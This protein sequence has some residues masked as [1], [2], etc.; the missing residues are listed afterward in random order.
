M[1]EPIKTVE[2]FIA[3]T[4]QLDGR[5]L[6]YRGLADTDWRV[7][8]SALRRQRVSSE[9]PP[10]MAFQNYTKQ[11]L[12]NASLQG[13]RYQRDREMS[14]LELL[15]EL[16]HYGA[17]TCLIDFTE[18]SLIALWF[19]CRDELK[20]NGKVVAMATDDPNKFRNVT[21]EQSK[22]PILQFLNKG[23]LWQWTPSSLNNRIVAQLSVFVFGEG[24]IQ[25]N[26]YD[27]IGIEAEAK[28]SIIATL[29]GSFGLNDHRVFSD[30]S[31]YALNNAHDRPYNDY[32][33]E[34][35][36]YWGLSFHRQG[37]FENA[38]D[39]YGK[40]ISLDPRSVVS[41]DN[42]GSA[43]SA[44]GDHKAAISDYDKSIEIYPQSADAFYNRGNSKRALGQHK[45]AIAD[46]DRAIEINPQFADVYVN[47]GSVK[48]QMGDHYG[49]IADCDKALEIYPQLDVAFDN[50][51]SAKLELGNYQGSIADY[52]KS[53]EINPLSP[54][55]Y[56]NRG[57]VKRTMGDFQGAIQ[58]YDK[59]LEIEPRSVATYT[60]RAIAKK[61]I[62]DLAGAE[63]D[64]ERASEIQQ[65]RQPPKP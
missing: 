23:N 31:G 56:Y 7:E 2:E 9:D 61:A 32:T 27:E 11:L 51:G 20:T 44:T 60:N 39:Y 48:G 22:R 21:Y 42:R 19:A 5:M 17:A 6:L 4:E 45:G 64:I 25:E 8:S 65:N 28:P 46:Y 58:D 43:K 34:D 55:T 62:G 59:S 40:A 12:D 13:F 35:F 50:R 18:N 54:A 49:A 38:I 16:Q 41:Y 37:Q 14:D 30:L 1:S 26:L 53:L 3:W 47:R 24:A 52:D 63:A 36:F 10:P 33:A 29:D 15:A 57:N